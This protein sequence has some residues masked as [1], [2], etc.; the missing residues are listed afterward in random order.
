ME[1]N[2]HTSRTH[3]A[4]WEA[5][6][7]YVSPRDVLQDPSMTVDEKRALLASWASDARAVTD[8]PALRQ[9]ENGA[10]VFIDDV[11]DALKQLDEPG[12][13]STSA[14]HRASWSPQQKA[15]RSLLFKLGLSRTRHHRDDD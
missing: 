10:I 5:C 3:K 12:A 2:E 6:A 8:A 1:M 4:D 7:F 14:R 13:M 9:L 11:L 15:R